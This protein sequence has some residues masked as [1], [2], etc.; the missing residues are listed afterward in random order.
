M[1]LSASPSISTRPAA[2]DA[3]ADG[4]RV[5][6]SFH[7]DGPTITL[8]R[9]VNAF[10]PDIADVALAGS[11]FASHYAAP[12]PRACAAP[13]A[14]M[15]NAA[16]PKAEAVS[17]ILHGEGFAVLDLAQGWAWGYSL[18]D[19]YVGYVAASALGAPV[20]ADHVVMAREAIVFA[21]PSIKTAALATLPFASK[22]SGTIDGNFLALAEGGFV[23]ARHV[24]P[25]DQR[26]SDP[27]AIAEAL[28]GAPY[29]WGGRG[30]GG[31]DCSGLVQIALAASGVT[32]PRDTD[33]QR[34]QTGDE[35]PEE[36]RLRRGD[37]IYFPGHVGMMV[38][39]ER[40]IHANAHWMAVTVEPLADVTARLKPDHDRP[41]LSRRRLPQ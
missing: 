37:L 3:A 20:A 39:E 31:I 36:A 10:R 29:L 13:A 24:A 8:D 41:I 30:G 4:K 34:T 15:R 17:Q 5:T 6:R 27:V 22:L 11:L 7:L 1:T 23:H 28:L 25:L 12:M 14:M 35:L 38:D 21:G 16:D 19:H 9:R 18:H 2:A 33:Q 40:L 26:A 32:A